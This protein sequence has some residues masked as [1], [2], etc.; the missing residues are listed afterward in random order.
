MIYIL[1]RPIFSIIPS[2]VGILYK[3]NKEMGEDGEEEE[4][5]EE[6]EKKKRKMMG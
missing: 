1:L 2:N 6:E 5:E 3:G 4:E